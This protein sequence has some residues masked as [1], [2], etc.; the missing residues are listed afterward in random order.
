[1]RDGVRVRFR[2]DGKLQ[3]IMKIPPQMTLPLISR[4]KVVSNMDVTERRRP[5]DGHFGLNI[6]DNYYDF[7]I[8][9]LPTHLGEKIVIRVLEKSTVLKGLSDLG[10]D[11][12]QEKTMDTLIHKP[13]GMILVTG[14][15]GSGKTTTLYSALN[16]LNDMERNIVTIEDPVEYQI[17]G[18]N[19]VQADYNID[20]TFANGLRSI[21]RQDP[22]IIMVGE[23][24]DDET[25]RIAVR[26]AL[27]GHL[28]FSTLH[29]NQTVGAANAL[30]QMG[31][32]PYLS[33]SALIAVITQRLVR[34]I[35]PQC[36]TKY[37]PE[38]AV[39]E[40]IG[41]KPDAAPAYYKGVGCEF[42]LNTGYYGRIGVYEILVVDNDIRSAIVDNKPEHEIYEL[43]QSK[44]MTTL[45]N[46]G[47]K[48]IVDGLTT[49]QEVE[50]KIFLA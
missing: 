4:I 32:S 10:L 9:S 3:N 31:V 20:L 1:M 47:R 15:T 22:D 42:C 27:T 23:I 50:E 11:K 29:A 16:M 12:D 25:A 36:K 26:S 48:K 7:R 37:K 13:Y 14:P 41:L 49:P 6:E 44:G 33:S 40:D 8:S 45:A 28:V 30:I 19:Q 5:Q 21:L 46:N 35:C 34:R 2:V 24:R 43:A 18:I 39:L 38:A 17:E